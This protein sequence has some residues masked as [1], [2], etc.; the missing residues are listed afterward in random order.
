MAELGGYVG[1]FLNVDLSTGTLSDEHPDPALLRAFIGGYGLGAAILYERVPVDADPLGPDNML[2]LI[3]GPLTGTP[4]IMASRYCAVAKS[5][6]TGGW[7]DA[8]SGGDFGPILKYAGYD[9]VFV[10]GIADEPVYLLIEDGQAEI[11][12]AGDLWGLD[13]VETEEALQARHGPGN[14]RGLYRSRRRTPFPRVVHHQR[15]R[16]GGGSFRPGRRDGLKATQGGGRGW[17][18][19]TGRSS[20]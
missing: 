8:N 5:P 16:A 19:Q 10:R 17:H 15:P 7:G 12:P 20:A 3:T 2:G 13:A 14:P 11:R 9:A 18:A 4:A 6:L 1:Q